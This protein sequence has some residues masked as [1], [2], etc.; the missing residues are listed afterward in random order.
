MR[1]L[2][3]KMEF[4]PIGTLW[5]YGRYNQNPYG[6][7]LSIQLIHSQ[8]INPILSSYLFLISWLPVWVLLCSNYFFIFGSPRRR[9]MLE[10][11][12]SLEGLY[13]LAEVHRWLLLMIVFWIWRVLLPLL[14]LWVPLTWTEFPR[15][16]SDPTL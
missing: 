5:K 6:S 9:G 15:R 3:A 7:R 16:S 2:G 8:A 11:F 13:L 10:D 1:R 14:L 4:A 12:A